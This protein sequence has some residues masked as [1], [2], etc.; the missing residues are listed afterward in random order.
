MPRRHSL[1][2]AVMFAIQSAAMAS[3]LAISNPA[4]IATVATSR[5]DFELYGANDPIDVMKASKSWSDH[6]RC[7]QG[8][9][10]ALFQ[11]KL[12]LAGDAK[13]WRLGVFHRRDALAQGNDD[14]IR[15]A[16]LLDRGD[17][18][19]PGSTYDVDY[20][21]EYFAANGVRLGRAMAFDAGGLGKFRSGVALSYLR[22]TRVRL[23]HG[24]GHADVATADKLSFYGIRE[25]L[26][27]G[28]NTGDPNQFNP[29]VRE[30]NP[31]GDGFSTDVGISWELPQGV[32]IN[33]V[34]SDL[35]ARI[36]WRDIP[37]TV[38]AGAVTYDNNGKLVGAENGAASLVEQDSRVAVTQRLKEKWLVNASAPFGAYRALAELSYIDGLWIPQIGG[39]YVVNE[40]TTVGLSYDTRFKAWQM[41]MS[42]LGL[43]LSLYAS[44]LNLA[45]ASAL[46]LAVHTAGKGL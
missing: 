41:Q 46:G 16:P 30:G 37:Q 45:R 40:R 38:T 6:V 29:Y 12:E 44:D 34:V 11:T 32:K 4:E 23:E 25:R 3:P 39:A 24:A 18:L 15:L 31:S 5:L 27:S 17:V 28:L 26:D 19:T 20:R 21:M 1:V 42:W 8:N 9:N 13:G 35:G 33:A 36:R 22:G 10:F 14:V 2:L 43:G 7:C